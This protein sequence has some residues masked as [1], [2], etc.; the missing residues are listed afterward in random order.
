[1]VKPFNIIGLYRSHALED[2]RVVGQRYFLDSFL[3]AVDCL[4]TSKEK[5]H[6]SRFLGVQRAGQPPG[7]E[8]FCHLPARFGWRAHDSG[9]VALVCQKSVFEMARS[10]GEQEGKKAL[11][12]TQGVGDRRRVESLESKRPNDL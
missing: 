3:P 5:H 8:L 2:C 7:F 11:R 10:V 4:G 6:S 1:M 12:N 9:A